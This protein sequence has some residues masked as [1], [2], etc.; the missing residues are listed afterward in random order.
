MNLWIRYAI[1]VL[2]CYMLWTLL[3]EYAIKKHKDCSCITF[4]TLIIAGILGVLA[5]HLHTKYECKHSKNIIDTFKSTS[6]IIY[7]IILT[8][9]T[10]III[11]NYF[12]T[13]SINSG[14]NSGTIFTLANTYVIPVTFI[15]AYL[16]NTNLTL[17]KLAGTFITLSGS[18]LL[19]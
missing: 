5:L 6:L 4:Q 10:L 8:V 15:S 12:V 13:K 18:Y 1:L 3:L 19:I 17:G 11:S 14:G 9:A 7:I 2:I 16:Y